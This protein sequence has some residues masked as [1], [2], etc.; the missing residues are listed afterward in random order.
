MRQLR[1]LLLGLLV[2][3]ACGSARAQEPIAGQPYQVPPGYEMYGPGTLISYG[4][5]NYVVQGD[6]TM[7]PSAPVFYPTQQVGVYYQPAYRY[8][9]PHYWQ[10]SYHYR[11]QRRWR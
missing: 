9:H 8:Y 1:P 7:L 4:G 6:G 11:Y 5:F 2:V 10:P 3:L